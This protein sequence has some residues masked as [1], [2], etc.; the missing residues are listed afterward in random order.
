M[1]RD[2][3]EELFE[4]VGRVVFRRMFGGLGIFRDG[5]MF[6]LVTVDTLYL[7]AD[8]ESSALFEAEGCEPFG[9]DTKAGRRTIT[10]YWRLPE[11]LLDEPDEFRLW[12]LRSADLARQ[13][14]A[15]K[16]EF[17][18]KAAPKTKKPAGKAAGRLR[19]D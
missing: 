1:D 18:G 12:A 19:E 6:G 3:L 8:P 15:A 16:A 7:K 13:L 14:D 2:F 4:P 11:R 10:S 17:K 5:L 9:Y